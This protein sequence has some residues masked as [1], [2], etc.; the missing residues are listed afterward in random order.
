[1]HQR[2][3]FK[4]VYELY[5][6]INRRL[7]VTQKQ[8]KITLTYLM[9]MYCMLHSSKLQRMLN[10]LLDEVQGLSVVADHDDALALLARLPRG[11][12]GLH[13]PAQ[14]AHLACKK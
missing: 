7:D 10:Y 6:Q 2:I 8:G 3:S 12:H 11:A 1:M 5:Q 9:Q 4:C 14:H 13:H